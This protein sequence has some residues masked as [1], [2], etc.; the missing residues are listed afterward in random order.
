MKLGAHETPS[1]WR[2]SRLAKFQTVFYLM[3][4][5]LPKKWLDS[6]RRK[7]KRAWNSG[8]YFITYRIYLR[9]I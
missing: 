7:I 6:G 5:E 4:S 3:L 8:S 1:E 9:L 2:F